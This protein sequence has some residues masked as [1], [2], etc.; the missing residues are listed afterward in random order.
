MGTNTSKTFAFLGHKPDDLGGY[1]EDNPINMWV[2]FSIKTL[3]AHLVKQHKETIFL[4]SCQ[5]GAELW[6]T[7]EIL[8]FKEKHPDSLISTKL[9]LPFKD[10]T[11]RNITGKPV[12]K[13]PWPMETHNRYMKAFDGIENK[14]FVSE[15]ECPQ[16]DARPLAYMK[17]NQYVVDNSDG[18]LLVLK[19]NCDKGPIHSVA[20]YAQS[21]KRE[22]CIIDPITESIGVGYDR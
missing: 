15:E 18:V 16:G 4:C 22:L 10:M 1:K 8:S 21:E 6:A 7:E 5:P 17:K 13:N 20:T 9:I 3:V 12:S 11:G 19:S 2:K 14:I